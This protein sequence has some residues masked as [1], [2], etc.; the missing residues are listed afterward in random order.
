[1]LGVTPPYGRRFVDADAGRDAQNT[2]VISHDLWRTLFNA[3]PN[4]I[5]K[6]TGRSSSL[7]SWRSSP[8]R[9]AAS[10]LSSTPREVELNDF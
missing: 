10:S 2:V 3:D 7:G 9:R 5:G 8:A 1:M 4:V 6:Q